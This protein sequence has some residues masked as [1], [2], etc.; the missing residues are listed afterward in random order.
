MLDFASTKLAI[1]A[2]N[3]LHGV[4]VRDEDGAELPAKLKISYEKR[5]RTNY[6]FDW[7]MGHPRIVLPLVVALLAAF[8]VA[9]FDPYG[10]FLVVWWQ[11]LLIHKQYT[12]FLHKDAHHAI[13]PRHRQQSLQVVRIAGVQPIVFETVRR[14]RSRHGCTLARSQG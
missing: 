4:S 12:D 13:L 5:Q 3:C 14:D 11:N 8:T 1:M 6:F 7:L 10:T 2:K 9:V